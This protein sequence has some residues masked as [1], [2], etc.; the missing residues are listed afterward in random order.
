MI[1][2]TIVPCSK[3]VK[4]CVIGTLSTWTHL[5]QLVS[6]NTWPLLHVRVVT[7]IGPIGFICVLKGMRTRY[8][9]WVSLKYR[10]CEIARPFS[11]VWIARKTLVLW[12]GFDTL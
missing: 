12:H 6:V 7:L 5:T 10:L 8:V 4:Q 3:A 9:L 11:S 1:S 2:Q